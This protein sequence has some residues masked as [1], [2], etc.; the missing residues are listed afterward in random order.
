MTKR[1]AASLLA[2]AALAT[3]TATAGPP[4]E[5]LL[6]DA[7]FTPAE[8]A[9]VE[10]GEFVTKAIAPSSPRELTAGFAFVVAA[11]PDA[12]VR[13]VRAGL[14]DHVDP[15]TVAF[16]IL[17]ASPGLADFAKLTLAPDPAKQAAAYV[18]AKPGGNLNLSSEEIAAFDTLGRGAAVPAVE[19]AVRQAL[20][21]RVQAYQAKGLAGIAPYALS[22]GQQ[23]SPG[24]ELRSASQAAKLLEKYLPAAYQMLVAYPESRPPGTQETFRWSRLVANGVP[25]VALTQTLTI[26]DGDA[27]VGVQRQFYVSTGYNSEQAI[28]ALLPVPK[29]TI[30]FYVNRTSTDQV[31]GF[32]GSAAIDRQQAARVRAAG[33]V[34]Q[35]GQ[36]GFREAVTRRFRPSPMPCS[37]P[38]R[39]TAPGSSAPERCGCR[40]CGRSR[41]RRAR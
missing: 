3:R 1:L 36:G 19:Q 35:G 31:T 38:R 8:I 21:A 29:G 33:P 22:G 6:G 20:L 40:R 5:Q 34:S 2:L 9:R 17:P 13:Q 7:G 11:A 26:P 10:N 16:A 14:V 28:A 15:N 39:A 23:R 24:D 30:V 18:A 4:A 32:G 12:I 25:T 37:T 41:S 27:W